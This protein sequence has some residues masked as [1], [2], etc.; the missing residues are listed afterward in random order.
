MRK[1]NTLLPTKRGVPHDNE[2]RT[3]GNTEKDKPRKFILG[4]RS[5][6]EPYHGALRRKSSAI[7]LVGD[8]NKE[9]DGKTHAQHQSPFFAQL[10]I[11]IRKIVYEYVVG[12][13][14]IH[15]LFAKKRFGHFICP[16]GEDEE[17]CDCKVLV[18]G[19]HVQHLSNACVRMLVICRR[20][21][22]DVLSIR[23]LEKLTEG[24]VYRSSFTLIL[25]SHFLPSSC[26]SSFVFT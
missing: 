1:L 20:M 12:Q 24:Q 15:L 9:L 13:E 17:E 5:S 2:P 22:V 3:S 8:V 21:L 23:F 25:S 19:A 4:R 18:G 14:T 11:E 16:E 10:P 7:S 26:H 6:S